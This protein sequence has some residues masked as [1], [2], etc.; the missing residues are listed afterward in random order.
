[1]TIHLLVGAQYELVIKSVTNCLGSGLFE[2]FKLATSSLKRKLS[3]E[4]IEREK[5][6]E[7]T[8]TAIDYMYVLSLI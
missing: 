3:F 4:Y 7:M 2:R 5:L 8:S 1:M 6:E